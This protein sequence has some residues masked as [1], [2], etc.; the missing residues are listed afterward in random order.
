MLARA[1][2]KLLECLIP[3]S[4]GD[5]ILGDLREG[6]RDAGRRGR[7]AAGWHVSR[8]V[9]MI[10]Y[11]AVVRAM[12]ALRRI[13]AG[14]RGVRVTRAWGLSMASVWQDGWYA[15]RSLASQRW[16]SLVAVGMLALAIGIATAMFTIVDAL[17]LRPVPFEDVDRL[18]HL[19]MIDDRGRGGFGVSADVLRAWQG[20]AAF[21]AV[22][23]ARPTYAWVGFE[24]GEIRR[25][26]ARV[27]PG[28]FDMLGGVQPL[29]GRLFGFAEGRSGS[30]ARVLISED[31][32]RSLYGADP[33]LV[34]RTVPIDGD[35]A[36][37]VGILPSEFRFP[38][39]VTVVWLVDNFDD[40]DARPPAAYVRFVPTM[41]RET[42][43]ELATRAAHEVGA[44]S[45][46]R[47]TPRPLASRP[48]DY[49]KRT[50]QMLSGGVVLLFIVLCANVAGLLLG[51][52]TSRVHEFSTR[53]ALGA[54]RAR[55]VRQALLEAALLGAAGG[56]AGAAFG[57]LLVA[58]I[59]SILPEAALGSSLNTLDID[60]RALGAASIAGLVAMFGIGLLPPVLGTRADV[61]RL[62]Q[63][64]GHAT[65][66]GRARV[67]TRA[68]LVCQV[69]LSCTLVFGATLLVR[70]FVN[71]VS[72]DRGVDVRNVLMAQVGF[73]AESFATSESRAS[74]A[75]EV[76]D[77]A[78][79]LP[80]ITAVSWSIGTPPLG[81]NYSGDW[82]SDLP[83]AQPINMLVS[84]FMVDGAFF[85][86]YGVPILRGRSFQTSDDR[87]AV[88]IS[89]RFARALWQG[90][91]P[92]GRTFSFDGSAP[93][94]NAQFQ[95]A[96]LVRDIHFPS[97]DTIDPPQVYAP[98][99]E[100][101]GGVIVMLSLRCDGMCPDPLQ[102]R[103]RL[104]DAHPDV[105]IM[106]VGRVEGRYLMRLERPRA[107]ATLA[108]AFAVTALIAA[109][110]GLFSLFSQSVIRRRRELGIRTALGASPVH[111]RRLVWSDGLVVTLLGIALGA[112]ASVLLTRVLSSLL[113]DVA[114]SDPL[115]WA[116]VALTLGVAIV[117]AAW[118]PTRSAVRAAP[119]ALLREE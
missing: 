102:V 24:G 72:Q 84:Y 42:A 56:A 8:L 99:R 103:R 59:R 68:L 79:A 1:L 31:L 88:L 36:V 23:A 97:L 70:S 45:E 2:E 67:A 16:R 117:A 49:Y 54:P 7:W 61:R 114:T 89:E 46:Q 12:N 17:L 85:D 40:P 47:A 48:G 110:T 105:N 108:S 21:E 119:V 82:T 77:A 76:E 94:D 91:D 35:P 118:H 52:L 60:V 92:I 58:A 65:P 6:R 18:A 50:I 93:F 14:D 90:Q 66:T 4:D 13:G 28:L 26:V 10:L 39:P 27:T 3:S 64:A 25:V 75:G 111:L 5:E 43:L 81:S 95:V 30:D 106:D 116:V 112:C 63:T 38:D 104:G 109:A 100:F 19:L 78:R 113:F 83:G 44:G 29:H 80:G 69:A 22:E 62:L 53:R 11:Y 74:V 37:V 34:G 98:F 15:A 33:S 57:W 20:S 71:L 101:I 87:T 73:S 86:L 55:L 32:W 51:G 115:S 96:G 9:G 107:A 41:P